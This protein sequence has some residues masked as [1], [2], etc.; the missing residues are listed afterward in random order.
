MVPGV[1]RTLSVAV[2][3]T[4]FETVL[5]SVDRWVG[6]GVVGLTVLQKRVRIGVAHSSQVLDEVVNEVVDEVVNEGVLAAAA[7]A[8]PSKTASITTWTAAA[9]PGWANVFRQPVSLPVPG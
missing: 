7:G 1:I 9:S 5:G 2:L 3:Q 4:T 8:L 6:G